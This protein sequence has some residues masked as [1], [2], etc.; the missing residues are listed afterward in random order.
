MVF[1]KELSWRWE[2]IPPVKVNRATVSCGNF[3]AE[4]YMLRWAIIFLII[5]LIAG[6]FGFANLSVF[7]RRI[8]FLL[9]ALFFIGFLVLLGFALL[10]VNAV[11][12]TSIGTSVLISAIE[13]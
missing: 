12:G 13:A 2:P 8:S 7:T 10:V 3:A 6:G 4:D 9:F 1:D 5:S 11:D